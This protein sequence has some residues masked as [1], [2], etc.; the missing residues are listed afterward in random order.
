MKKKGV[1]IAKE[2]GF[3]VMLKT[4]A[5]GGGKGMR[6]VKDDEW[7][8]AFKGQRM[9]EGQ[10]WRRQNF[11]RKIYHGTAPHRNSNSCR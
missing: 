3:P 8:M 10:L 11:C 6:V 4:S 2:I 1:K 9:R 5:G 7:L